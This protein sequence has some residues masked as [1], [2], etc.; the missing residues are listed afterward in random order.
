MPELL[1]LLS[2]KNIIIFILVLTRIS[3]L[4]VSA[5]FF[6]TFRIP[7]MIKIFFAAFI[8]FIIY[9]V[10]AAKT[11]IVLPHSMPQLTILLLLEFAIGFLIGFVTDFLF[12]SIRM[13]G[14]IVSIQMGLSM[15][16]ILDPSTGERTAVISTSYI[17]LATLVFFAIGAQNW[18]FEAL[19]RSF[20]AMPIGLAGV[21]N[22]NLVQEV[23]LLSGQIFQIGFGLIIPIFSVLLVC[24][25]LLG[26]LSKMLPQMNIFMVSLPFKV[27]TG[28]LLVLVFLTGSANYLKD[29]MVQF[30]QA[31]NSMFG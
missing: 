1:T 21:L 2:P 3:G 25:I 28:L 8:S 18:L 27:Y 6:S 14:S 29:V 26:L 19:Y 30:M 17:Y 22:G 20:F 5:P 7:N 23:L 24:D 13:A 10:V 15:A 9:P 11:T 31:V 4:L 16:D 12:Q